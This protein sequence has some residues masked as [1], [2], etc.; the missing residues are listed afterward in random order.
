MAVVNTRDG[1]FKGKRVNHHTMEFHI[2]YPK[3][4]RVGEVGLCT[5]EMVIEWEDQERKVRFTEIKVEPSETADFRI[6]IEGKT[7]KSAKISL[8]RLKKYSYTAPVGP[9]YIGRPIK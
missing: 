6:V 1:I 8:Q 5:I 2:D 3:L 4:Q 7:F 9:K